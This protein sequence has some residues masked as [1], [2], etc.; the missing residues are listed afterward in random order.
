MNVVWLR[1][2]WPGNKRIFFKGI[3]KN[4]KKAGITL[5]FKSSQDLLIQN[6]NEFR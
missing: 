5:F 2:D 3:H 4:R 1:N 6:Q